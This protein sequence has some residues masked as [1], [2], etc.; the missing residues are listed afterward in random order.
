[1]DTTLDVLVI[2]SHPGAADRAVDELSGDGHVVHRCHESDRA[3][4]CVGLERDRRCP[5]EAHVD[6]ALVVRRGVV[7]SPTPFEDGVPC[8]LRAG[9]P[10][11]E[12]GTDLHDPYVEHLSARVRTDESLSAACSRAVDEAMRPEAERV[13]SA[14]VPFLRANGL[15]DDAV[16]VVLEA[17]RDAL[18]IHLAA[19]GDQQ[20]GSL[21]TGQLSVKAVD[22]VRRMRRTWSTIECDAAF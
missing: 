15:P 2:E 4:P 6:V 20:I 9:I 5:V 11:V 18:R 17:H 12:H 14:L 13:E 22:V 21:L 7:P 19:R 16:E 1:M 10:V 8:A 3:F